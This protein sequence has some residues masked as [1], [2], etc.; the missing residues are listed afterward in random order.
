[1]EIGKWKLE[2]RKEKT[3]KRERYK[4]ES[5]TEVMKVESGVV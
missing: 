4:V 1:M 3:V 2:K 5:Q